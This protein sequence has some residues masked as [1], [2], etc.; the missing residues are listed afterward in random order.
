MHNN[1]PTNIQ[2]QSRKRIQFQICSESQSWV[3]PSETEQ[4]ARL[5]SLPRYVGHEVNSRFWTDNIFLFTSYGLSARHEPIFMS[6]LWTIED[7]AFQCYKPQGISQKINSGQLAEVWLLQHKVIRVEWQYNRYIMVVSPVERGVQFI[8][9]P[10][11]ERQFPLILKVVAENGTEL[12]TLS[13][14][15]SPIVTARLLR[16]KQA[17][18]NS[19]RISRPQNVAQQPK[20]E[21]ITWR[22]FVEQGGG[23]YIQNDYDLPS[24]FRNGYVYFNTGASVIGAYI[25]KQGLSSY[26]PL[27]VG[28]QQQINPDIGDKYLKSGKAIFF[29][30][31]LSNGSFQRYGKDTEIRS[32]EKGGGGCLALTCLEAPFMTNEQISRILRSG[33]PIAQKN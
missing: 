9:F 2:A 24:E 29:S 31:S 3:R 16:V 7:S 13:A 10:R 26:P 18:G 5:K 19:Q 32:H 25:L 12:A 27:K 23:R 30:W 14:P 33:R 4:I 22:E 6:G 20:S 1:Y 15:G 28:G 8:Q 21:L 17:T 11:V